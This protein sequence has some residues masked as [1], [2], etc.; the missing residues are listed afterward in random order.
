MQDEKGSVILS[1]EYSKESKGNLNN[2]SVHKPTDDELEAEKKL[3][4]KLDIV[5][6]PLFTLICGYKAIIASRTTHYIVFRLLQLHRQ[7]FYR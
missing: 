5:L 2:D 7:D 3:V 4:R 1:D 6:L